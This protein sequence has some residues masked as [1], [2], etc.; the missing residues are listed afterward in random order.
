MYNANALSGRRLEFPNSIF[1]RAGQLLKLSDIMI[2]C[3]CERMA[4]WG[5]FA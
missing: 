2:F 1:R 4:G 3:T 5:S